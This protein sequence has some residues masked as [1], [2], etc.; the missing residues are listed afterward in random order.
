MDDV[1]LYVLRRP[2]TLGGETISSLSL[3]EPTVD[4]LDRAQRR[5]DTA[6]HVVIL[7]ITYIAGV[8][9]AAVRRMGQRDW[10]AINAYLQGFSE[11]GP[12]AGAVESRTSP[13]STDGDP[14][15]AQA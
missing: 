1:T 10:T 5:G 9:E 2:V 11:G 14:A 4:E 8:S 6:M 13:A 15:T 12:A 3:R 7:L